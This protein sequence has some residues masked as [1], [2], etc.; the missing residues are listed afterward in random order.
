MLM[1]IMR[2]PSSMCQEVFMIKNVE[3][4][5]LWTFLIGRKFN[6]GLQ[7]GRPSKQSFGS[8]RY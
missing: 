2:I 6:Q 7:A 4:T 8:K 5:V 3:N 1:K